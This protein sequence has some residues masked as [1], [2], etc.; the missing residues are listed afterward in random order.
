ME[1]DRNLYK[2]T[3]V[4]VPQRWCRNGGCILSDNV[5]KGT[6]QAFSKRFPKNL[7]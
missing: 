7:K 5:S 2:P 6:F 4:F 1:F 3:S